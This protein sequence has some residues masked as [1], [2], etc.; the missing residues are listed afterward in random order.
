[1]SKKICGV[2]FFGFSGSGKTHLSRKLS[3]KTKNSVIVDGDEVRKYVSFDLNHSKKD[4]EIQIKRIF[5]ISKIVINSGKFPIISS[6]YF[7]NQ[8]NELC[9]KNKIIPIKIVRKKFEK[10]KKFHTTYKKKRI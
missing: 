8:I 9:K 7:N 5:G 1:M 4:R 2:W 6:V 3:R 10:V